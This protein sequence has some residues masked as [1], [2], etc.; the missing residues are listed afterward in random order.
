MTLLTDSSINERIRRAEALFHTGDYRG[1]LAVAETLAAALDESAT[2][3]VSAGAWSVV[4]RIRC[5]MGRYADAEAAGLRALAA[6][7]STVGRED[8]AYATGVRELA[9]VY[10]E[11][12]RPTQAEGLDRQALAIRRQALGNDHPDTAQS[13]SDL[14]V[15]L[16]WLGRFAES[17]ECARE[18]VGIFARAE[19]THHPGRPRALVNFGY[20]ALW[21]GDYSTGRTAIAEAHRLAEVIFPTGHPERASAECAQGRLL[22]SDLRAEPAAQLISA[23]LAARRA[24][25]GEDHPYCASAL[26][27]L[28]GVRVL[29]RAPED[30]ERLIR[31]AL[32][33][34]EAAFGPTH[35]RVAEACDRL[36]GALADRM[37]NA[38]AESFFRRASG[39]QERTL[40]PDNPLVLDAELGLARVLTQTARA[41]EAVARCRELT[42][43]PRAWPLA[44]SGARWALAR[45][46]GELGYMAEAAAEAEADVR[47]LREL[48]AVAPAWLAHALGLLSGYKLATGAVAEGLAAAREALDVMTASAGADHPATVETGRALVAAHQQNGDPVAAEAVVRRLMAGAPEAIKLDL[49]IDLAAAVAAQGKLEEAERLYSQLVADRRQR[50]PE[51]PELAVGLLAL[52]LFYEGCG[53]PGA[54]EP[55]YR[56]ALDICRATEGPDGVGVAR[57]LQ[58]LA[59]LH[60]RAGMFPVA[61][62]EYQQALE[63]CRRGAGEESAEFAACRHAVAELHLDIGNFTEAEKEIRAVTEKLIRQGERSPGYLAAQRTLAAVLAATA[64]HAEA[65]DTLLSV[66]AATCASVGANHPSTVAVRSELAA[67]YLAEGDL[68]AAQPLIG[69]AAEWNRQRLPN[70]P[71]LALD[72]SR[73]AQVHTRFGEFEAAHRH[74]DRYITLVQRS[75]GPDSPAYACGQVLRAEVHVLG[76]DT[77]A[78]LQAAQQALDIRR[79]ALGTSH[80]LVALVYQHVAGLQHD[81]GRF[82]EARALATEATAVIR[83]AFGPDHPEFAM[84]LRSEAGLTQR[85]DPA[86]AG[87]LLQQAVEL[88]RRCFGDNSPLRL[89]G[90]LARGD[91]HLERKE[92]RAAEDLFRTAAGILRLAGSEVNLSEAVVSDRLATV[93]ARTSRATEAG[94]YLQ[95]TLDIAT[96][97]FGPEHPDTSAAARRL[98]WW[99]SARGAHSDALTVVE[100]MI[101]GE[102]AWAE[103]AGDA[104][105]AFTWYRSASDAILTDRLRIGLLAQTPGA[106]IGSAYTRLLR[107]REREAALISRSEGA[108]GGET[109][110]QLRRLRVQLVES[111]LAGPVNTKPETHFARLARWRADE[112]RAAAGLPGAPE[113][114]PHQ[115]ASAL[116]PNAVL[117]EFVRVVPENADEDRSRYAGFILRAGG[118]PQLVELG[119]AAEIDQLVGEW[120]TALAKGTVGEEAH[121]RKVTARVLEP[122]RPHLGAAGELFVVGDTAL[123]TV[124]FAAL[125][126]LDGGRLVDRFVVTLLTS[127]AQLLDAHPRVVGCHPTVVTGSARGGLGRW[128]GRIFTGR[129]PAG[130]GLAAQLGARRHDATGDWAGAL[131][132]GVVH[133]A[134]PGVLRADPP[135]ELDNPAPRFVAPPSRYGARWEALDLTAARVRA[136]HLPPGAVV[137][138]PQTVPVEGAGGAEALTWVARG[139][140]RAG[141]SAVVFGLWMTPERA[142]IWTAFHTALKAGTTPA[143]ALQ[144]AQL[145]ARQD[146]CS[147]T[148]W[149]GFV[150]VAG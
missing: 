125:P 14:S 38:D 6:L 123:R 13:L 87:A 124:P 72:E 104:A 66:L 20:A 1:A 76:G 19:H 39:I 144:Q 137:V 88:E 90:L 101:P 12:G 47:A 77:V 98:S 132:G 74:I 96:G 8:P 73:L 149:G 150:C 37:Q 75:E 95:R 51:D 148:E 52:G 122:L 26:L 117:V 145:R 79:R 50:G 18:A 130:V 58:S 141:A 9:R 126:A 25:L 65:R 85:A 83:R 5:E 17:K 99:H 94:H 119:S 108:G 86:A 80:P 84:A 121:G 107:N 28:A 27:A 115:I 127:T 138:A 89:P 11:L 44:L 60:H 105:T 56:E 116:P 40:G 29:E 10:E 133:V 110:T 100:R 92:Y 45:A 136:L 106:D 48:P 67:T 24:A 41:E 63:I 93:L 32:R 69:A 118:E 70:D 43:F 147:P 139:F 140:C 31:D 30:A 49:M 59:T 42:R 143:A 114:T 22:L 113:L 2:D 111:T 82:R 34:Y 15:V 21:L 131:E 33:I 81:L 23:A 4:C 102:D 46:L 120:Q 68:L 71:R 55:R 128:L 135:V 54:A 53:I 134:V 35:P 62:E 97:L 129:E 64:R 103:I 3:A 36:A 91:W 112:R 7:G 57:A 109:F 16:E 78:A 61:I 146:G 142:E